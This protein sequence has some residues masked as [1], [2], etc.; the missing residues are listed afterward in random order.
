MVN[1]SMNE[2]P[3]VMQITNRQE[4][5]S[6]KTIHPVRG[7]ILEKKAGKCIIQ[8]MFNRA[9]HCNKAAVMKIEKIRVTSRPTRR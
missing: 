3:N 7:Q 2:V 5:Q 9:E 1:F 4:M 6:M 8:L